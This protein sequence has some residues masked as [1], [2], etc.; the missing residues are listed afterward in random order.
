MKI[1]IA[2]GRS[3][4]DYRHIEKVLD[5]MK[6]KITSVVHGDAPGVDRIAAQW[7]SYNGIPVKAY[8]AD[9]N[10]FGAKA[11]PQRNLKMLSDNP[12][13][14]IVLIFKGGK[15]TGHM[16]HIAKG[17]RITVVNV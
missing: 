10:A 12:D 13:I 7:C 2:G 6:D 8:P 4:Y 16:A 3:N 9:W 17:S 1:L 5:S 14:E 15:G 11:G